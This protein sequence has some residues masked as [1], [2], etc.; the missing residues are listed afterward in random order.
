MKYPSVES[1][2]EKNITFTL[3]M[4]I[5]TIVLPEVMVVLEKSI[6]YPRNSS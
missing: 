6:G 4:G 1:S 3:D 5:S 2:R